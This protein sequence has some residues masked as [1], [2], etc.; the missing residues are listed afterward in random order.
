M[1]NSDYLSD[2]KRAEFEQIG[3]KA[4][5]FYLNFNA[6][7]ERAT[8]LG[9]SKELKSDAIYYRF[10]DAL[11]NASKYVTTYGE[12]EKE[13]LLNISKEI[14]TDDRI[15]NKDA[16]KMQKSILHELVINTKVTPDELYPIVRELMNFYEP[17]KIIENRTPGVT[18]LDVGYY[19]AAMGPNPKYAQEFLPEFVRQL[20]NLERYIDKE[21]EHYLAG[22]EGAY[23][24]KRVAE[25]KKRALENN[26][27][28]LMYVIDCL[29]NGK[30][31]S[32]K[33]RWNH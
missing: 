21:L 7:I 13:H 2:E 27:S 10:S 33:Y 5:R 30:S 28:R 29:S 3:K 32:T 9:G 24:Q 31:R 8:F 4:F 18:L 12:E 11:R 23:R 14:T 25:E 26:R 17:D 6:I 1:L 15:L 16:I 22:H 19:I 20:D